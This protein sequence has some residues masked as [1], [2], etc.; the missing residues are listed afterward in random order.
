MVLGND[1]YK[2]K[3]LDRIF[4]VKRIETII[5]NLEGNS[6]LEIGC[7]EGY[8]IGRI[9]R[10]KPEA[11]CVGMS[12]EEN[13]IKEARIG[14]P[15]VEFICKD[16]YDYDPDEKFDTV[17]L[18]EVIE[19][20]DE[21]KKILAKARR[22]AN[23]RIIITVPN[24]NKIDNETHYQIYDK[25][26]LEAHIKEAINPRSYNILPVAKDWYLLRTNPLL[27]RVVGRILWYLQMD[28]LFSLKADYKNALFFVAIVDV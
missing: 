11:R 12:N 6:F 5:E 28:D 17:I 19:H 16:V 21:P 22:I 1:P 23:R 15:S 14:H 13:G 25:D 7:G 4:Q 18:P 27:R 3:G 8:I 26:R 2:W 9:K 10:M 20:L 24:R